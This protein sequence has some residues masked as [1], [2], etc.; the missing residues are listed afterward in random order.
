MFS[1]MERANDILFAAFDANLFIEIRTAF[2]RGYDL[3]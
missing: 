2:S 3:E 1:S